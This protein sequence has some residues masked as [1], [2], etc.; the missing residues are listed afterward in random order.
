MDPQQRLL[1]EVAWECLESSGEGDWH[2]K[3][4]G[5]YV[6]VFRGDWLEVACKDTEVIDRY[7]AV[8]TGAFAL[9]NR[10]SHEFDLRGPRWVLIQLAFVLFFSSY[11]EIH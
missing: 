8:G 11:I 6:G 2:G 3:P 1:L 9:A 7:R 5:C 4:T 10:M